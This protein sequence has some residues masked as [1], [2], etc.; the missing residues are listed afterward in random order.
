MT[1]TQIRDAIN[2]RLSTLWPAIQARQAAYAASHNGDYWQG[3]ATHTGNPPLDNTDTAC[4]NLQ[5]RA[6]PNLPR[7]TD[8]WP[9][10]PTSLPFRLEM[11]EYNG[12]RGKGYL[13]VVTIRIS[14]LGVWQ[15]V[16]SFGP[17]DKSI[18]WTR[19][20]RN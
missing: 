15:R 18:P 19:M 11:H 12:P 9:S 17:E 10:I 2:V 13:L 6:R 3:L 1:P 14:G 7:W 5:T 16:L 4:N 20:V 8:V